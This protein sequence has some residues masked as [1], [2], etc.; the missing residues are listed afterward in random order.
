MCAPRHRE[1]VQN[2]SAGSVS[3][4]LQL[5][6][7]QPDSEYQARVLALM[8]AA[9]GRPSPDLLL[10]T[11]PAREVPAA[12]GWLQLTAVGATRLLARWEAVQPA[13][14]HYILYL[15]QVSTRVYPTEA[16]RCAVPSSASREL[17]E[18]GAGQQGR[19]RSPR[20][21]LPYADQCPHMVRLHWV[22][23]RII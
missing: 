8:G 4:S 2:T 6:G 7:L 5:R 23:C 21:R 3:T 15:A 14:D 11:R 19:L 20:R 9:A 16:G 10:R 22:K 13:P 12:P 18:S 17:R 1:R